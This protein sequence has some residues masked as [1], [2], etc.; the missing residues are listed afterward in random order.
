MQA[1]SHGKELKMVHNVIKFN[2]KSWLKPYIDLNTD[3]KKAAQNDF[4]KDFFK[5][6]NNEVLEKP[7]KIFENIETFNL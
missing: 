5:L 7:W 4:E 3:L 2:K 6:M 1:S